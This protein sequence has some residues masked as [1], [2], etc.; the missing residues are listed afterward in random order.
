MVNDED[1]PRTGKLRLAFTDSA[2]NLAAAAETQFTLAP[3]GAQS[4]TLT[5]QMPVG[6][7]YT[8]QAMATAT[9]DSAHSTISHRDVVVRNSPPGN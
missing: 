8:L 4:Y 6:G 9:D 5:L 2:G 7:V 1:R 3:L